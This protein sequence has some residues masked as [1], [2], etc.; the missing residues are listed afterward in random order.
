MHYHGKIRVKIVPKISATEVSKERFF[1]SRRVSNLFTGGK[2]E[3]ALNRL[4]S[5]HSTAL[6]RG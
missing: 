3:T 5:D 2:K 1:T 6:N 4:G